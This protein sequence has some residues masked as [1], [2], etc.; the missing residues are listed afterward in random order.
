MVFIGGPRQVGKTTLSKA[1]CYGDFAKSEYFNWDKGKDRK[2]I[3]DEQWLSDDSLVIFDELHKYLRWKSWIKGVYDTKPKHQQYLVTGSARLDV[4]KKGGDSLMGRYHYWRLHPFTMDEFPNEISPIEAYQRLLKIGG[5]PEPFL[6]ADEREARRW[7]RER[8]DRILREDIR[9]L[10]SIK[11]IQ[12][13]EF[14]ID[15]L[16]ERVGSL[17]TLSNIAADLQISPKTAKL[18]L[19]LVEKMYIAFSIAP[20]TKNLPRAIQKPPKVFFYDNG[21]VI[22]QDGARLENLVATTLL[23]RLHFIEDYYG[24]RTSLH[25]VRDKE[26]R[27]VDFLTIINGIVYELIEVKNTAAGVSTSLKYYSEKLKPKYTIQLVSNLTRSFNQD[28]MLVTNPIEYFNN[29]PWDGKF[30][31]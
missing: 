15:A 7:R 25:Y 27:E 10:E 30:E 13:L 18:W 8:F 21:D 24:Y 6:S 4:Y 22:E 17:I 2:A 20:Y 11:N 3:L 16:R 19:A 12:L 9:D 14:F 1:L 23:K 31:I 29:P 26:G 5:F 28:H